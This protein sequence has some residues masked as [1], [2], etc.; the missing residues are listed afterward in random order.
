MTDTLPRRSAAHRAAL[1]RYEVREVRDARWLESRLSDDRGY[2]AYA[3]GHLET[4]AVEWTRYWTAEGPAGDAVVMHAGAIG[5][6]TVV[7][8]APEAI[9]AILALHPGPRRGYLST[10]APEHLSALSTAYSVDDPLHM[11]RMSMTAATFDHVDGPVTRLRGTDARK[12]NA[13]YAT[14]GGPSHY[15]REVI[16]RAVYY[17]IVEDGQVVAAAGTHVVA[18][19]LG[20]AVVGNVFTHPLSR[21]RG[22]ATQVTSAVSRE[23]LHR[24]CAEVVLTVDPLNAPAVAAY[25]RLGYQPGPRVVEARIRRRDLAGIGP[26]LRRWTARRRGRGH[27]E[28]IEVVTAPDT[29]RT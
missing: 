3:L 10:A 7:T 20:I 26:A 19:N 11:M 29:H 18:P 16:E 15:T 17:G 22:Y 4:G 21:G 12:I 24:G 2:S 5:P 8:G 9:A 13:L 23:L 25:T 14:E 28:G 6:T 27:G 1:E